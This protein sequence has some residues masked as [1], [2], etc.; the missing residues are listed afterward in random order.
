MSGLIKISRL[1]TCNSSHQAIRFNS[2]V[3]KETIF[4]K[5]EVQSLLR[6]MTGMDNEKIFRLRREGNDP[7]KPIYQFMTEAELAEA[8]EEARLKAE[9]KLKMTPVMEER[10]STTRTLEEDPDMAG[11][12]T[13]KYVFT[14]ITFGVPD[15]SRIIVVREQNGTLRTSNW[16]EQDRLNQIYFPTEGRRHY[17]PAMFEPDNLQ[18]IL[19]PEK[20]EYILD[21]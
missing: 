20:Y 16:E 10:S 6:Q 7:V 14:D 13:S 5:S 11:F 1:L 12:D 9:T 19:G 4:F 21:R 3:A 2:T 15:R 8:R 17:T 18:Q